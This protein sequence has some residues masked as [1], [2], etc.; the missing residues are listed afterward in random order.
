[1]I[2]DALWEVALREDIDLV[3]L[4][5]AFEGLEERSY[6]APVTHFHPNHITHHIAA[7]HLLDSRSW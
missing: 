1:M 6:R 7:E 3:D 4:F 2:D 5:P